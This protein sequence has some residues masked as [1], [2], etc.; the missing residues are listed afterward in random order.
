MAL[1]DRDTQHEDYDAGLHT[2]FEPPSLAGHQEH[3]R[4]DKV[5][6]GVSAALMLAFIA[7]A[8]LARSR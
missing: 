4:I 5:V 7:W 2:P 1:H 8:W 6:F 3:Y